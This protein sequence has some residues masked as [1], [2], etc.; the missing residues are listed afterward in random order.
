MSS[1]YLL[2]CYL[3]DSRK[4]VKFIASCPESG[5]QSLH[6]YPRERESGREFSEIKRLF[7]IRSSYQDF[8]LEFS[9]TLFSST[10]HIL[11][12]SCCFLVLGSNEKINKV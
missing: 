3:L 6:L 5:P 9:F 11:W 8:S 12:V 10:S 4:V 7:K 1:L 2:P